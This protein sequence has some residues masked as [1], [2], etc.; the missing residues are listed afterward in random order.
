[1]GIGVRCVGWD[2]DS[3]TLPVVTLAQAMPKEKVR[4]AATRLVGWYL[5]ASNCRL[6]PL[7]LGNRS[8]RKGSPGSVFDL[9]YRLSAVASA[10]ELRP[11]PEGTRLGIVGLAVEQSTGL[12]G[13]KCL[14]NK[15]YNVG[16]C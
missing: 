2:R 5:L 1:M 3:T 9:K 10:T 15:A 8:I 13:G 16:E 12:V 6:R 7:F 14:S 11:T 4:P